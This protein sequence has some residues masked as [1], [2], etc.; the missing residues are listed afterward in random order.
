MNLDDF[1]NDIKKRFP[2]ISSRADQEYDAYW[3]SLVEMEFSSYFWFESLTNAI[4]REMRRNTPPED[5]LSLFDAIGQRYRD[6]QSEVKNAIDVAFVE[7]L[8]WQVPGGDSMP[9]WEIMPCNLKELYVG[10]HG[11]KPL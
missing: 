8:F 3:N 1:C 6:G 10:F 11:R 2:Y 4:N 9:F 7:N 5:C